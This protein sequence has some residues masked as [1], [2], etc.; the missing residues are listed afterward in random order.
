M[1]KK[2]AIFQEAY[3][4]EPALICVFVALALSMLLVG[5]SLKALQ[6][7]LPSRAQRML[8][9]LSPEILREPIMNM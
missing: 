4:V 6:A 8:Y 7:A 3:T 5:A 9:L 2:D 1:K